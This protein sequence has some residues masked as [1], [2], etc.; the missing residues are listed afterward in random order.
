MSSKFIAL[1]ISN[2]SLMSRHCIAV[3][4]WHYAGETNC[5]LVYVRCE[6]K[7]GLA[8]MFMVSICRSISARLDARCDPQDAGDW[9]VPSGGPAHVGGVGQSAD[10]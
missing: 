9:K 6:P 4:V 8:A 1:C 3:C 5:V 2:S 7:P 10:G